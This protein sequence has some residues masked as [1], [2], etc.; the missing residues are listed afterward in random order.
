[1]GARLRLCQQTIRKAASRNLIHRLKAFAKNLPV[2]E[3]HAYAQAIER[4]SRHRIS[5]AN[6]FE[7]AAVIDGS[8]DPIASRQ[9]TRSGSNAI[10]RIWR[11]FGLQPHRSETFKLSRDPWFIDEPW[12]IDKVRNSG[13]LY[14][15]PPACAMVLCV[16]KKGPAYDLD[17][18]N[19]LVICLVL[20]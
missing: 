7:A 4:A 9:F 17:G 5:A 16:N 15:N 3:A 1:M 14:L 19:L 20:M 12:F 2:S 8:R 13:G 6:F 10:R 18:I 11:A